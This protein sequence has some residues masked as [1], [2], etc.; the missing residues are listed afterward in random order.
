MYDPKP[1]NTDDVKLDKELL[2]LTEKIA[3]NIH[4]VWARGRMDEGWVYG[5]E[6]NSEKMTTPLLVPYEDLEE[7]EK[8][9]DRKTVLET[10]KMIITM[11]YDI[12]KKR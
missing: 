3:A 4:D 11:G 1:V 6:K 10:L 8:E 12:K 7:S 2:M 9:Y 5:E